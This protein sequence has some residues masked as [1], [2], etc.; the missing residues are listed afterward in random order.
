MQRALL[1]VDVDIKRDAASMNTYLL[2]LAGSD[3]VEAPLVV[4]CSRGNTHSQMRIT[5]P[6]V[7]L[8]PIR[9]MMSEAL[10]PW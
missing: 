6:V 10:A 2:L 8:T 5:T 7:R 4:Y 3:V 1:K 9:V